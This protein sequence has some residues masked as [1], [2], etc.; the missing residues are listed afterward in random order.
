ML[1]FCVSAFLQGKGYCLVGAGC[2]YK[3]WLVLQN[4]VGGQEVIP[5]AYIHGMGTLGECLCEWGDCYA[6]WRGFG[7]SIEGLGH[8]ISPGI[9]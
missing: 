3:L 2:S 6:G 1:F 4:F 9:S 5:L 7:T 8:V